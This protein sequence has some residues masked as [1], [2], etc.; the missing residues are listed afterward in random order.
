ML[1]YAGIDEAGY[2]PML[3]PFVVARS[4]FAMEPDGHAGWHGQAESAELARASDAHSAN[5]PAPEPRPLAPEPFMEPPCLWRRLN[6]VV[7]RRGTDKRRRIAVGDSKKLYTP[8]AG[9]GTL[10]RG[11][12]AFAELAGH[13]CDTLERLLHGLGMDGRSRTP[14]LLWYHDRD[15]GPVLPSAWT[16]ALMTMTHRRLRR[17][18]EPAGV[19]AADLAAAVVYEDRFNRI[20]AETGSK[21]D[22]AWRFVGEHLRAIW[23][24]Y[25]E[26]HPWVVV[27]RQG[28]RKV[29]HRL[30]ESLFDESAE[31]RLVDESEDVSRYVIYSESGPGGGHSGGR[32]MTVSFETKAD[33]R[34]LPV[35]LASM[36]AKYLRELLMSRFNRFWLSHRPAVRPTAGYYGDGR[37][38][39]ADIGPAIDCLGV[40][41]RD[42][43]RSK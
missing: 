28:G 32:A 5:A 43:V 38:F 13:S 29:Y 23:A 3:G 30:L 14:D 12:L 31:V 27:D 42:L 11:V 17:H 22:C 41:R 36:T 37:R 15:G 26:H 33:G 34:H 2:G 24:D 20:L 40:D 10:E 9:L 35:A 8:A 25:G 1:I 21:G 16:P 19:R 18:A 4:V 39:L 6:K 7:C